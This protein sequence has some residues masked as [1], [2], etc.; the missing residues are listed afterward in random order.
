MLGSSFGRGPLLS[1]ASG[2]LPFPQPI[3]TP[4]IDSV[5]KQFFRIYT[6][7]R[8]VRSSKLE[9]RSCITR[10][11]KNLLL[12]RHFVQQGYRSNIVAFKFFLI[13]A[14]TNL[15]DENVHFGFIKL[16]R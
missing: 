12:F 15:V 7:C 9:W 6:F 2:I 3:V 13:G 4:M 16:Q 14:L 11:I 10:W 1:G 5:L 8:S